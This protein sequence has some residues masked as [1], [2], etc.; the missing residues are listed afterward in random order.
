MSNT[1]WL[2]VMLN[3]VDDI[4]APTHEPG[5]NNPS[6]M[7]DIEHK[8]VDAGNVNITIDIPHPEDG[9]QDLPP[10]DKPDSE[11]PEETPVPEER[12][13][14][15]EQ[16]ETLKACFKYLDMV[17]G[18]IHAQLDYQ[19]RFRRHVPASE[20]FTQSLSNAIAGLGNVMGHVVTLFATT[21]VNAFQDFK[22]SELS[23]YYDSNMVTFKRIQ[24]T[25]FTEYRNL[26]VPTPKGMVGTYPA[27]LDCLTQ[28]LNEL[29]L[30]DLS[31]RMIELTNNIH[32]DLVK[33]NP[34]FSSVSSIGKTSLI[35][36]NVDRL[37]A[38]TSKIFTNSSKDSDSVYRLFGT[39]RALFKTIEACIDADVHFRSV[40]PIH[41]N[42]QVI[43]T[44]I[45]RIIALKEDKKIELDPKL[46]TEL[47]NVVRTWAEAFDI[48]ATCVNDLQRVNHNLMWVC[49]EI[50]ELLHY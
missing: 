3:A 24:S 16:E 25:D 31:K 4:P 14:G 27:A 2:D 39:D 22:R 36:K 21:L 6:P 42:L 1:H 41:S 8:E 33:Q 10:V 45:N 30:L 47:S 37:F 11:L 7:E 35:P 38:N 13:V 32:R 5:A 46:A 34:D 23:E 9:Y 20:S 15:P 29:N 43:S 44:N 19:H 18:Y 48:F 49:K 50:R 17:D 26:V 28:L 40:S 12:I